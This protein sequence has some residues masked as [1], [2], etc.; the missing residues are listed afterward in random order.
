[1]TETGYLK[2]GVLTY[3]RLSLDLSVMEAQVFALQI[4]G[5]GFN[6]VLKLV[7][8]AMTSREMAAL[9][10]AKLSKDM[11]VK[12]LQVN[13]LMPEYAETVFLNLL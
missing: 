4:A 10:I 6:K 13:V 9:T 2:T 8:T 3:V 7:M 12:T 11:N 5:M 1:M